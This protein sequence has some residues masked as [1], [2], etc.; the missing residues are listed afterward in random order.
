[1]GPQFLLNFF[2]FLGSNHARLK[3]NFSSGLLLNGVCYKSKGNRVI[4]INHRLN[5]LKRQARER[6]QSELDI[7]HLKKRC[8]D[9]APVFG[10]IKQYH[11][12]RRF[13]LRGKQKVAT[14]TGLLALAQNLRK[15]S[16]LNL[17]KA[18]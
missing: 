5:E 1:L 14:E 16:R 10:N 7:Y 18:A 8:C 12:F 17:K 15:K 6:L 11:G 2:V 13:M 9:T 3:T 4:E